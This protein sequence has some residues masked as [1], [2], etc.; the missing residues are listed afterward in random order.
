MTVTG[1]PQSVIVIVTLLPDDGSSLA[2]I[3]SWSPSSAIQ[4]VPGTG[5]V[6]PI[7]G[8]ILLTASALTFPVIRTVSTPL[9]VSRPSASGSEKLARMLARPFFSAQDRRR[10]VHLGRR[11]EV[12]ELAAGVDRA[13]EDSVEHHELDALETLAEEVDVGLA[14][15]ATAG[16]LVRSPSSDSIGSC[17]IVPC[18]VSRRCTLVWFLVV[19]LDCCSSV[20]AS[21][22][23]LADSS[24]FEQLDRKAT[25][26]TRAAKIANRRERMSA[27]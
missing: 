10:V 16:T 3:S 13:V 24:D 9:S 26:K 5:P 8:A 4:A 18:T 27:S 2:C 19:S 25:A 7:C 1:L 17:S 23:S 14:W 22:R 12:L 21:G 6:A 15:A 20:A 11:P